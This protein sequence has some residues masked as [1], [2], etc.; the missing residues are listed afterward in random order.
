[1][2]LSRK[3]FEKR[4]CTDGCIGCRDSAS[5]K[6]RAG[7]FISPHNGA[8]RRR[9]EN[10]VREADSIIWERYLVRQR[11]EEAAPERESGSVPSGGAAPP[12]VAGRDATTQ[13]SEAGDDG[14]L[15]GLSVVKSHFGLLHARSKPKGW[16]RAWRS[17]AGQPRLGA[18]LRVGCMISM[19]SPNLFVDQAGMRINST[20]TSLPSS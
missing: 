9:M 10:A 12:A 3:D 8:S 20:C 6:A 18:R 7:S 2:Y 5:G 19:C 1:M 11:Q 16:H 13:A 15:N 4:G 17:F 14:W